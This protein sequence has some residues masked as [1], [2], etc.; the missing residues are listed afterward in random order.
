[1][2]AGTTSTPSVRGALAECRQDP[3]PDPIENSFGEADNTPAITRDHAIDNFTRGVEDFERRFLVKGVELRPNPRLGR[4]VIRSI[5]AMVMK[6]RSKPLVD[7]LQH[8]GLAG[9]VGDLRSIR[10]VVVVHLQFSR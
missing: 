10:E 3:Q 1:M 7:C 4:H 5:D 8:L 2:V 9:L 6:L